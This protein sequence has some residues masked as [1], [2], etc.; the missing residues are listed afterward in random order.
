MD[1][2]KLDN[3]LIMKEIF[4]KNS[5]GKK[6]SS[7]DRGQREIHAVEL[8]ALQRPGSAERKRDANKGYQDSQA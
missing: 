7:A 6:I 8:R 3:P 1:P 5:E 4:V 2:L